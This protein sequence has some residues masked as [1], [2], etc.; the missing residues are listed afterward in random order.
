MQQFSIIAEC[1]QTD[2]HS[3]HYFDPLL[4]FKKCYFSI[5]N[6]LDLMHIGRPVFFQL[7]LQALI[8]HLTHMSGQNKFNTISET[9]RKFYTTTDGYR[10]LLK[11]LAELNSHR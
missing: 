1:A 3:K 9:L 11:F 4:I 7:T 8:V 6:Q 2:R 5:I 10:E